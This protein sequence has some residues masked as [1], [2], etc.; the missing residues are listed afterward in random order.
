LDVPSDARFLEQHER[1]TP[2][3]G[4][5]LD[6]HFAIAREAAGQA[7]RVVN[8][9]HAAL[10]LMSDWF[11]PP[12]R[13]SLNVAGGFALPGRPL[14]WPPGAG[15]VSVPLHWLTPT[16]DQR[17]ERELIDGIAREYWVSSRAPSP[18]EHAL[19][20][21]VTAR[22]SHQLLE[23]SNFATPTF[24]GGFVPFPLRSVLLSPPVADPRPRA[25]GF[26]DPSLDL[27]GELRR[28]I[29]ALQVIERYV[30]WP[31]MLEA[32]SRLRTAERRDAETLAATLS[33]VRG[34][35]MRPLIME[36][37]RPDAVFDYSLHSLHSQ[38]GSAGLVE[39]TLTISRN[40][41]GMFAVGTEDG[42]REAAMPV[43]VRFAD[44]SEV[45]DFF[46]GSAPSATLIYSART[47]A[48]SAAIDPGVMLLLDVDREN[49]AI[50]HDAGTAPLGVRLALHWMTWLQNAMLSYTALL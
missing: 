40:G 8:I 46:D 32:L 23:G 43:V 35:D 34:T 13:S 44:G 31:T 38:P 48:V 36:C 14:R 41:S 3:G 21:Y 4:A 16:R 5:P 22:A 9:T 20:A 7:T 26:D 30:G 15:V 11:G 29:R 33:E 42:D 47:A 49:N 25:W 27:K 37:L 12:F 28:D 1:F 50:V 10:T 45:R 2:D 6:L 19:I 24:F 39:T 17:T 18:F